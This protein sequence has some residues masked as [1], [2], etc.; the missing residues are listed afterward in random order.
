MAAP[1]DKTL[2]NLNGQ[3]TVVSG[4]DLSDSQKDTV[5]PLFVAGASR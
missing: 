2:K 5:K 3:W 1:A 4:D